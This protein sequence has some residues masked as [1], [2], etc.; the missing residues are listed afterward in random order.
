MKKGKLL[1]VGTALLT[2]L[3]FATGVKADGPTRIYPVYGNGNTVNWDN[4]NFMQ[5]TQIQGSCKEYVVSNDS[6]AE[7]EE[8]TL[9][10]GSEVINLNKVA[11]SG[12]YVLVTTQEQPQ[13]NY[14]LAGEVDG[15][16][17]GDPADVPGFV[18]YEFYDQFADAS[19]YIN[20]ANNEANN[21][22]YVTIISKYL[23]DMFSSAQTLT[24]NKN[25]TVITQYLDVLNLVNNGKIKT[26]SIS[27]NNVTGNG[28]IELVYNA[29]PEGDPF[30]DANRLSISSISGVSVDVKN[31]NVNKG[32]HFGFL[33]W[34]DEISKEDAQKL[35]DQLNKVKGSTL[36]GYKVV[37]KETTLLTEDPNT[38]G[39]GFEND[40]F[41]IG[42]LEKD[43]TAAT[44]NSAKNNIVNKLKAAVKNPKTADALFTILGTLVLA[45]GV[46]VVT[47]KKAKQK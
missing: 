31:A 1:L 24:I 17:D 21:G 41:Y 2:S 7:D 26:G 43:E 14:F 20:I 8:I 22:R 3:M 45:G 27:A 5:C 13:D 29:Y 35:V 28:H 36:N 33:G 37:L 47:V 16:G 12:G 18:Y 10:N 9:T 42:V 39:V 25:V 30:I 34:D 46:F 6:G 11:L 44:A 23:S 32:M 15:I 4:Q 40:K 19:E 38:A